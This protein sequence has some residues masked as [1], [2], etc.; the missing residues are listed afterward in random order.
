MTRRQLALASLA[1]AAL[2]AQTHVKESYPGPLAKFS[3]EVNPAEFDTLAWTL[4]LY[5]TMP[6][7]MRFDATTKKAAEVWQKKLRAKV[8]ELIGGFPQRTP[9]QPRILEKKEF[10]GYTRET[11]V[12]QSRPGL[13]VFAY[14]LIPEGR[15]APH[16]AVVSIPGH[17]RGVDD[18]VG[19]DENGQDR[20]TKPPYAYDYG[21]QVVE[22]GM[23]AFAIEPFGFGC[24]RDAAARKVG[25]GHSSCQPAAGAALL[26][27][28]TM[29]AWRVWDVMRSIDYL[30]TR[31]ELDPQ[32]IGC[33]GI[34]G[35][36]TITVFASALDTRIQAAL[37]SGYLNTFR[38]SI[39]SL[40]HCIDNYV[41]GIL[42]WCEQYDVAGL[43][44]PRP[45]WCES[46]EKDPIFPIEA[47]RQSY[48]KVE[49]VYQVMGATD[50]IGM[51]IH[52]GEHVFH[53]K[54]GLPFLAKRLQAV[55]EAQK[56]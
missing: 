5:D 9:L 23:A 6:R 8:T 10:P 28:Q 13:G 21:I 56:S 12:F 15:K 18:I 26:F 32:R 42:E 7:R 45:L 34:S 43:I 52:P 47:F 29:V 35:G 51:E 1:P 49:K 31:P 27:G 19:V 40:S 11:I 46:G 20:T 37:V 55:G 22:N 30:Q 41:P 48:A 24:R 25:A 53:G 3:A 2:K 4:K 16:P 38:D 33:M 54:K 44:A 39:L 50:R 17:G 14:L 36:G